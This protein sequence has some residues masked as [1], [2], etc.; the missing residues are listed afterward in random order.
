MLSEEQNRALTQVGRPLAESALFVLPAAA[1]IGAL[2]YRSLARRF[3]Q[4]EAPPRAKSM[5]TWFVEI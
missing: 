4:M 5:D 2:L 3:A 1:A